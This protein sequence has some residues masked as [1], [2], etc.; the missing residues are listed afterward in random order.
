MHFVLGLKEM[1]VSRSEKLLVIFCH[2]IICF[3]TD[4]FLHCGL[5]NSVRIS[6]KTHEKK[7]KEDK[8]DEHRPQRPDIPGNLKQK[9]LGR[10]F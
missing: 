4:L 8:N 2:D 10:H 5:D 1:S 3:S 6:G 7:K 9:T